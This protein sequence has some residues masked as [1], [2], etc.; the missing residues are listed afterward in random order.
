[1]EKGLGSEADLC[2]DKIRDLQLDTAFIKQTLNGKE[3]SKLKAEED[4]KGFNLV[5]ASRPSSLAQSTISK[6]THSL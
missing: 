3:G 6:L 5:E 2:K 1:V 4:V